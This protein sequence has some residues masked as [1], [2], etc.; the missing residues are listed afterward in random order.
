MFRKV[1]SITAGE[2][3]P[4]S[5]QGSPPDNIQQSPLENIQWSPL[6]N[7][8]QYPLSDTS[9]SF[10]R[11]TPPVNDYHKPDDLPYSAINRPNHLPISDEAEDLN[12]PYPK[13]LTIFPSKHA[14]SELSISQINRSQLIDA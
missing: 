6:E 7:S 8:Q 4:D 3:Q 14:I 9:V 2:V 13:C 10:D 12:P 1:Y 11:H 5:I